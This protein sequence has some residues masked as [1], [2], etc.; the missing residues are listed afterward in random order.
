MELREF[1]TGVGI[2]GF[3][4]E[5]SS[6]SPASTSAPQCWDSKSPCPSWLLPQPCKGWHTQRVSK[7]TILK[8]IFIVLFNHPD[9]W[10][11][12]VLKMWVNAQVNWLLPGRCRLQ[13][14][15]WY[16][17][18]NAVPQGL[19]PHLLHQF[20]VPRKQPGYSTDHFVYQWSWKGFNWSFVKF[21]YSSCN[22]F[23]LFS[24]CSYSFVMLVL[25][26]Y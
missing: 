10:R 21:G 26:I 3:V 11:C 12:R 24:L 25:Q 4:H 15:S 9:C 7:P 20:S 8:N 1:D 16:V 22:F 6:T 18:V 5:F 19:N 17:F 2:A 13:A 23:P 14:Q